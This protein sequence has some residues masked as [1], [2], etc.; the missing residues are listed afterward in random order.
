MIDAIA[1]ARSK[2]NASR[3]ALENANAAAEKLYSAC[4]CDAH[5]SYTNIK[6]TVNS[7]AHSMMKSKTLLKYINCTVAAGSRSDDCWPN[8]GKTDIDFKE[9]NV[10][11]AADTECSVFSSGAGDEDGDK[12]KAVDLEVAP[13]MEQMSSSWAALL[14]TDA[15]NIKR[16]GSTAEGGKS[17]F[18]YVNLGEM[19]WVSCMKEVAKWGLTL[20]S[21]DYTKAGGWGTHRVGNA[22]E[23]FQYW[24]A[25]NFADINTRHDCVA[26]TIEQMW[27]ETFFARSQLIETVQKDGE[28]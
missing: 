21:D 18:K 28:T 5:S 23:A 8:Q 22:A 12:Y 25:P 10:V 7:S 4:A 19:T 15:C 3:I 2:A 16:S 11:L 6:S 17:Y 24:Y 1:L 14:Q 26:G 20:C 27:T 13:T 9:G